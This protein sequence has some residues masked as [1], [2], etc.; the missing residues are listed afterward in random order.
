MFNRQ[1]Q[2]RYEYLE[3][4]K[5]QSIGPFAW[6]TACGILVSARYCGT[7]QKNV[8]AADYGINSRQIRYALDQTSAKPSLD[9]IVDFALLR[10]EPRPPLRR[11]H[12]MRDDSVEQLRTELVNLLQRQVEAL[13][14]E[15]Y[16]GLTDAEL[17]EFYKRQERIR[18]LKAGLGPPSLRLPYD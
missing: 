4:T 1:S 9:F 12:Q 18:D 8:L 13:E 15:T 10:P 5:G 17:R 16:V 14:L 11:R 2:V 3:I 6:G 7:Q